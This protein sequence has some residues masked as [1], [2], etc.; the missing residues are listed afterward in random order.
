MNLHSRLMLIASPLSPRYRTPTIHRTI[1]QTPNLSSTPEKQS[2]DPFSHPPLSSG[3]FYHLTAKISHPPERKPRQAQH[4]IPLHPA[5]SCE[6]RWGWRAPKNV[7]RWNRKAWAISWIAAGRI[8]IPSSYYPHIWQ[9]TSCQ[10]NKN[11]LYPQIY[12]SLL[13]GFVEN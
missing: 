7:E 13:N 2:R 4:G 3:V 6:D 10:A 11:G 8:Q 9:I 1:R 5:R 12:K